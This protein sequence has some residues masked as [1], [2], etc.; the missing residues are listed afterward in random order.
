MMQTVMKR[1]WQLIVLAAAQVLVCNHFHLLGYATPMIYVLLLCYIP[2]NANRVV[3]MCWAFALGFIIDFLS[4]TPGLASASLTLAAFV[5]RPLLEALAPKERAEDF[6]ASYRSLG[7][8]RHIFFM[9]ML[10]LI[11]HT[12]FV[13]LEYMSFYS[14]LDALFTLVSSVVLSMIVM[15][16]LETARDRKRPRQSADA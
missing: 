3:T 10:T 6:T 5:Q 12:V 16:T 13:A 2:I 11:H 9:L 4:A 1:I 14:P 15:L 8:G 7:T